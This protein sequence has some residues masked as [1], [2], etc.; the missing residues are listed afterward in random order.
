MEL[1]LWFFVGSFISKYT[2][3]KENILQHLC[4]MHLLDGRFRSD[5]SMTKLIRIVN[6]SKP[7]SEIFWMCWFVYLACADLWLNG[8]CDRTVWLTRSTTFHSPLRAAG[9]PHVSRGLNP[10]RTCPC[11]AEDRLRP[12]WNMLEE[13]WVWDLG[14]GWWGTQANYFVIWVK[15]APSAFAI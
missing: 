4:L 11:Q 13:V 5:V 7:G 8:L 9:A 15:F 2:L 1:V 10:I 3:F 6:I 12:W 14:A